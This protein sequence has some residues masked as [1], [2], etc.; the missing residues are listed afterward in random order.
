MHEFEILIKFTLGEAAL[1]MIIK[2]ILEAFVFLFL[3][4]SVCFVFF[5]FKP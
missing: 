2:N 5:F 3:P 4:F 1:M